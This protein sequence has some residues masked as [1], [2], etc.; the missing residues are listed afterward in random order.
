MYDQGKRSSAFNYDSEMTV[1]QVSSH[2]GLNGMWWQDPSDQA[3]LQVM[4]RSDFSSIS[5]SAIGAAEMSMRTNIQRAVSFQYGTCSTELDGQCLRTLNTREKG[6]S[7]A[8][9]RLSQRARCEG[10]KSRPFSCRIELGGL[11]DF[12]MVQFTIETSVIND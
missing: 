5:S 12:V 4:H 7:F 6:W 2:L 11:Q 8:P 10:A 3:C 1:Q 9:V